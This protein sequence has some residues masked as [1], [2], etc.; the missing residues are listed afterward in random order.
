[1]F[2][3]AFPS[4]DDHKKLGKNYLYL[5]QQFADQTLPEELL[6][7]ISIATGISKDDLREDYD[8]F[9]AEQELSKKL[10]QNTMNTFGAYSLS[11]HD[12]VERLKEDEKAIGRY[13]EEVIYNYQGKFLNQD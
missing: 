9:L 12:V 4:D 1:M 7:V 10:F 13:S 11:I 6:N 2:K 5:S 3:F 8:N